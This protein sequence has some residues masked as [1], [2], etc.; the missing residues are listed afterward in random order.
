MPA[1]PHGRT[2]T[3]AIHNGGF[4]GCFMY[5]LACH[6]SY[7]ND[8]SHHLRRKSFMEFHGDETMLTR[9]QDLGNCVKPPLRMFCF[10]FI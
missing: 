3:E 9:F 8:M 6:I 10:I 4:M 1:A 2:V 7:F 5:Y